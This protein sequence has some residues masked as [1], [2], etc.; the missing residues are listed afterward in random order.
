[1]AVET[2]QSWEQK[3]VLLE[4]KLV[5]SKN[6]RNALQSLQQDLLR[7]NSDLP[8]DQMT[9]ELNK[10]ID[11]LEDA[12]ASAVDAAPATKAHIGLAQ[13]TEAV[14]SEKKPT[15][16]CTLEEQQVLKVLR[17]LAANSTDAKTRNAAINHVLRFYLQL[18]NGIGAVVAK[19]AIE[20]L[21]YQAIGHNTPAQQQTTELPKLEALPKAILKSLDVFDPMLIE[22]SSETAIPTAAQAYYLDLLTQGQQSPLDD[23]IAIG[24]IHVYLVLCKETNIF[25]LIAEIERD[26]HAN[27]ILLNTETREITAELQEIRDLFRSAL[28]GID[29][30]EQL[31]AALTKFGQRDSVL[32]DQQADPDEYIV[33]LVLEQLAAA[34]CEILAYADNP[35]YREYF[36]RVFPEGHRE[37]L[38]RWF[39]SAEFSQIRGQIRMNILQRHREIYAKAYAENQ[40]APWIHSLC[41]AVLNEA[42]HHVEQELRKKA[43]VAN[44]PHGILYAVQMRVD[45]HVV[46]TDLEV[47]NK[48]PNNGQVQPKVQGRL[49]PFQ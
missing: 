16:T 18:A 11:D 37:I 32:F 6:D 41:E 2:K 13:E 12:I 10:R 44:I 33:N 28:E 30:D 21:F 34:F 31:A 40:Q 35:T 4:S 29:T 5:Q 19:Q 36:M 43:E 26:M 7:L 38:Q 20:S 17:S 3:L 46:R 27:D 9:R 45:E 42:Q 15:I 22:N 48:H 24:L 25:P 39:L 47:G 14:A 23:Y 1:M 49:S 8:L